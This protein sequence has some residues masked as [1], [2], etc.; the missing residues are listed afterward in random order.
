MKSFLRVHEC[1]KL[2]SAVAL[3][4]DFLQDLTGSWFMLNVQVEIQ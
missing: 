2:V 4:D 3:F 1:I